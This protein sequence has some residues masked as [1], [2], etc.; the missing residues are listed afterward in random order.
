MNGGEETTTAPDVTAMLTGHESNEIPTSTANLNGK[1]ARGFGLGKIQI[2]VSNEKNS[3]A[4]DNRKLVAAHAYMLAGIEAH[5]IRKQDGTY[6]VQE[7]YILKNPWGINQ[8][9]PM[10]LDELKQFFCAYDE[11]DVS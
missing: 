5:A 9:A 7:L 11:G 10:T 3:V 6:E 1:L 2:L 8:P 4:A